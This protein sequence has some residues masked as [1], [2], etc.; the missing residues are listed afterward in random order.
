[1]TFHCALEGQGWDYA[2]L[3]FGIIWCKPDLDVWSTQYYEIRL[4]Y[5]DDLMVVE[6]I[7]TYLC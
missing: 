1:M 5:V 3:E 7:P 2:E 6:C 4:E